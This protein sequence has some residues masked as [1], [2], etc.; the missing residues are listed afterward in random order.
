MLN[1][2]AQFKACLEVDGPAPG[3]VVTDPVCGGTFTAAAAAASIK[4]VGQ[5]YYFCHPICLQAFLA[6]PLAYVFCHQSHRESAVR[7][8]A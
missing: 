1:L 6:D 8:E 4:F 3:Q 5:A 7:P 2:L